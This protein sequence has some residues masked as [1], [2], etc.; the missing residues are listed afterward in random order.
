MATYAVKAR[1]RVLSELEEQ[2]PN[3]VWKL[4][5]RLATVKGEFA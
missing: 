3:K 4:T 2:F 1:F 5:I